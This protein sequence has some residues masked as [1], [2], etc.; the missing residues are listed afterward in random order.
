MHVHVHTDNHIQGSQDLNDSVAA[1]VHAALERFG[2]QITR[3]EVHLNDT[4]A[5][6]NGA[7]DKRCLIEVK[8]AG[9]QPIAVS[10]EADDLDAAI[11]AALEKIERTL[12]HTL[13]RIHDS[14][15]RV[16]MS[17]Q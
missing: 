5:Q 6:K 8:Y 12:D 4:N 13:D 15:G 7:N 14:K 1:E 11:S 3:V 16:S 17:G 9:H 10:H 2:E